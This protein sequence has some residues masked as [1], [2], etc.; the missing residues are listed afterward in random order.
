MRIFADVDAI[1][2]NY[3]VTRRNV[4]ASD[5]V[6]N[7]PDGLTYKQPAGRQCLMWV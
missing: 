3:D 5:V 6:V 2:G 1:D 7:V 4:A